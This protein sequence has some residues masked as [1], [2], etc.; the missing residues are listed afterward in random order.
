M[1]GRRS[2]VNLIKR[3]YGRRVSRL[4]K[5]ERREFQPLYMQGDYTSN[6]SCRGR[7]AEP[8][9]VVKRNH[10]QILAPLIESS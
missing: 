1:Q 10:R 9:R 6:V 4:E 8:A 7:N 5:S 2:E 3:Q